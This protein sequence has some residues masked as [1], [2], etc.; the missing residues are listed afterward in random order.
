MESITKNKKNKVQVKII[1]ENNVS[2][3]ANKTYEEKNLDYLN[4]GI[5][6]SD[7]INP[8]VALDNYLQIVNHSSILPQCI[9]AYKNNVAG[10]G[11]GV[12]Y[13]DQFN[14]AKE[15]DDMKKEFDNLSFII[16]C[17]TLE[18][19]TKELFEEVIDDMETYA[20]SF[21]E[22][23]RDAEGKVVELC[24]IEDPSTILKSALQKECVDVIF[25][26]NGLYITRPKRFRK[27]RQNVNGETIYFKELGDPRTMDMRTGEYIDISSSSQSFKLAN[28][29][30][31]FKIGRGIYGTPRWIGTVISTDGARR[32]ENLNENYFINGRH[33][34]MMIIVKN[35]TLSDKSWDDLQQYVN[36]IKGEAGQHSFLVLEAENFE[37]KTVL[38]DKS[39][40]EVEIK[41]LAEI[42]QKD[43]LFSNYIESSR[44]KI[45][46]AFMLPDIFVGY[47][48][49]YNRATSFASIE[50][51]E[52]QVFTGYRRSLEWI[53]NNK[54]L[55]DY[56]FKY[57]E[58]YFKGPDLTNI[59]DL[60]KILTIAEKG[61]SIT[62]NFLKELTYKTIGKE[63]EDFKN[64]WA[65]IPLAVQQ[66][67]IQQE[68]LKQQQ[69]SI[70]TEQTPKSNEQI[71]DNKQ[72]DEISKNTNDEL[73][74]HLKDVKKQMLK[75]QKIQVNTNV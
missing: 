28:E 31:E 67:L 46:S 11:I 64:D 13:K 51:T 30:I 3:S 55:N 57:V 7:Y 2:A 19:N 47:S 37:G 53:I 27:Y 15:T 8:D 21:V 40:V 38:D 72:N 20:I 65:N 66:M 68:Q 69:I 63:S 75:L 1:K 22:V 36:S 52:K 50:I 35:G 71:I 49:D 24:K 18:K 17:L 9:R 54:L 5:G 58:V 12:K 70:N 60:F 32:A 6:L 61:G 44:K 4:S 10:F 26:K 33:T 59:D 29:I 41:P 48:T 42:L 25:E 16:D 74:S 39:N 34:P 23:I 56:N 73:I 62:P 45:Q 14:G 43:E